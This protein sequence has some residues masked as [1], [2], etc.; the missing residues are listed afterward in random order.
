MAHSRYSAA[1]TT[2][3]PEGRYLRWRPDRRSAAPAAAAARHLVFRR[4]PPSGAGRRARAMVLVSRADGGGAG[5][6][7][8]GRANRPRAAHTPTW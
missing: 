8:R 7:E 5:D 2:P 6:R 4:G 1:P 3:P